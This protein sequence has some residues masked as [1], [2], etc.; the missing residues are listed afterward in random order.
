MG[1]RRSRRWAWRSRLTAW[2]ILLLIGLAVGCQPLFG[3]NYGARNR[4]RLRS[5]LK[6]SMLAS[7]ILG[8]T[9]LIIFTLTGKHIIAVFSSIPEVVAQGSYVLTAVSSAAPIIGVVMI[10]MNCLQAFGK[11]VPLAHSLD[12]TA[13]PLLYTPAFHA[14]RDFRLS[15]ARVYAADRRCADA[16]HGNRD[17]SLRFQERPGFKRSGNSRRDKR[18]SGEGS[19]LTQVTIA[20][21]SIKLL[22]VD[23][24]WSTFTGI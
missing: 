18:K 6:T 24:V 13:G 2:I 5:I 16:R 22:P 17:A 20:K 11:S 14:Q 10:T 12:R 8:T 9:M 19:S 7:F 15:R 1:R 23:P 3:F 21:I 4:T